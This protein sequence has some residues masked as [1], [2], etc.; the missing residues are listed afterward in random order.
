MYKVIRTIFC[1]KARDVVNSNRFNGLR[2]SQALK[3]SKSEIVTKERNLEN[4][5]KELKAPE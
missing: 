2:C 1:N 4:N 3:R 5:E